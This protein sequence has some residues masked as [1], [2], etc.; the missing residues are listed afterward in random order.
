MEIDQQ[1]FG[2]L[3]DM[4]RRTASTQPNKALFWGKEQGAWIPWTWGAVWNQTLLFSAAAVAM[5]MEEGQR[6]AVFAANRPEWFIADFG[7]Q[8]LGG[9]SVPVYM[10]A[11]EEQARFILDHCD[12]QFVVVDTP[13][14]MEV[15]CSIWEHLP[16]LKKVICAGNIEIPDD[17]RVVSFRDF[18][19]SGDGADARAA[20]KRACSAVKRSDVCTISYTSGTTGVPKGVMLTHENFLFVMASVLDYGHL[21]EPGKEVSMSYLPLAH[22]AQRIGDYSS[23]YVGSEIYCI[24][25]VYRFAEEFSS[26]RPTQFVAVPRILEKIYEMI[27]DQVRKANPRRQKIFAWAERIA[28]R[29]YEDYV[30]GRVP[31]LKERMETAL[32]DRLVFRRIRDRLGG[33]VKGIMAGGSPVPPKIGAFFFGVGLPVYE[34]YGLTETTAPISH[35]DPQEIRYGTVG[36]VVKGGEVRIADDDEILYRGPNVFQGYYLR[37]DA[38]AE[39]LEPDGWFHTGDLGS[40]DDRGFLRITGRKKDLI[41]TAGGKNI[42]PAPIEEA[43]R[44]H[45]WISQSVV[46]GDNQ[47]YLVA[48]LTLCPEHREEMSRELELEPEEDHART[49]AVISAL[50]AH[51][52]AVNDTL[53]RVQTIKSFRL[54]NQDFS[55][56][57]GEMTLSMKVRRSRVSDN[58]AAV[59]RDMYGADYLEM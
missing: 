16:N 30:S 42:A 50:K 11:N 3:P 33:R 31:S 17:P 57:S 28:H 15:V 4:I 21:I 40:L 37:P 9:I 34:I 23:M 32:A 35:P 53:P 25:D 38:T 55:V 26:I 1:E 24:E 45:P 10:H 49:P 13:E 52:D 46:I 47:K 12:A 2:S 56:E 41:I 14:R 18:L 59:I 58:Y 39:A 29:R 51:V 19:S 8:S 44:M 5:G 36:K 54:L 27:H 48:L 20:A 43:L 6:A 22:I 7:I